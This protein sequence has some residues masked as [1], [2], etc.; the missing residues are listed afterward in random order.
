MMIAI[1]ALRSG[2]TVSIPWFRRDARAQTLYLVQSRRFP[3]LVKVGYT[4]R[5]TTVRRREL[6]ADLG[7]ELKICFTIGMPRAWHAEQV[8]HQMLRARGWQLCWS[9]GLGG[10]WYVLPRE[11]KLDAVRDVMMA[12]A[13]H[14]ERRSRR[15]FSWPTRGRSTIRIFRPGRDVETRL[16]LLE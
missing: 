16:S 6:E 7:D 14:V 5:R 12:A 3:T 2:I 9:H 10:E 11:G 1:P 4:S 13:R 8:A 15:R